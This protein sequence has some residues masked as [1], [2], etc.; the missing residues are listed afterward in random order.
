M[1]EA[2]LLAGAVVA[3]AAPPESGWTV[4]GAVGGGR[5]AW[6]VGAP[7]APIY[8]PAVGEIALGAEVSH[9][10]PRGL[11]LGGALAFAPG[12]V[13]AMRTEDP[14]RSPDFYVGPPAEMGAVVAHGGGVLRVGWAHRLGS[15]ALGGGLVRPPLGEAR[16]ALV[17]SVR[18]HLGPAHIVYAW[19]EW[20]AFPRGASDRLA[21]P[22]GGLGHA[23]PRV[24]LEAGAGPTAARALLGGRVAPGVRVGVEGGFSGGVAVEAPEQ[25]RRVLLRF[26][27]RP[28]DR[29]AA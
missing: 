9:V 18:A 15:V 6:S 17:P 7:P 4:G 8:R 19:G 13:A 11:L 29:D 10:G 23:G 26:S 1:L 20:G 14:P 16:P 21:G 12:V 25:D 3:A 28:A 27:V 5:A 2:L 24:W 22:M